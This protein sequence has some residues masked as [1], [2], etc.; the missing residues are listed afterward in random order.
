[1][2][3]AS[4]D[5]NVAVEQQFPEVRV[6]WFANLKKI[7]ELSFNRIGKFFIIYFSK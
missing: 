3:A 4:M 1:M 5:E 2:P 7:H 6:T